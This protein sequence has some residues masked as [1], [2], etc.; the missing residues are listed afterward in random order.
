MDHLICS[1]RKPYVCRCVVQRIT[2]KEKSP[3]SEVAQEVDEYSNKD[4]TGGVEKFRAFTDHYIR[5]VESFA[6]ARLGER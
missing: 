6:A 5:Y 2:S 1:I 4:S 3:C